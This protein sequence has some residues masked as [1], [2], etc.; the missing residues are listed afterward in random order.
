MA[1]QLNQTRSTPV[2]DTEG[3]KGGRRQ[4]GVHASRRGESQQATESGLNRR[5]TGSNLT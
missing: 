2:A 5:I 1:G 4:H 3:R